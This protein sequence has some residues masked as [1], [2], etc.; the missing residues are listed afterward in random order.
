MLIIFSANVYPRH[1]IGTQVELSNIGDDLYLIKLE[2][3][4]D[5]ASGGAPFDNPAILGIFFESADGTIIDSESQNLISPT[6]VSID[7][8]QDD[9]TFSINSLCVEKATYTIE[10]VIIPNSNTQFIYLVNQRCCRNPIISNIFNP[11][12]IGIS[13]LIKIEVTEAMLSNTTPALNPN[14]FFEVCA[15]N[16]FEFDVAAQDI[17]G[18]EVKYELWNP[19]VGGGF[20]GGPGNPGDPTACTGLVPNPTCPP[21]YDPVPFISPTFSFD[22]PLGPGSTLTIDENTGVISGVTQLLG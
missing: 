7:P 10:T 12:E 3:F 1:I 11:D 21:P 22:L 8:L 14:L 17:D 5:C 15:D 19:F 9:C 4:R 2:V 6:V 20:L 13:G 18:D 16:E